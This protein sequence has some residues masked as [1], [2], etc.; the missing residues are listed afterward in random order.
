MSTC[1]NVR[2]WM[3]PPIS[4]GIAAE[5]GAFPIAWFRVGHLR[6]HHPLHLAWYL[7]GSS[8]APGVV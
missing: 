1:E 8:K 3:L 6:Y 5:P 4:S 2:L 7:Q